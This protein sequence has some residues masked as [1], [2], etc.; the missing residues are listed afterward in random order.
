[1]D[2]CDTITWC[3]LVLIL[4]NLSAGFT[5]CIILLVK[6]WLINHYIQKN[7]T[8]RSLGYMGDRNAINI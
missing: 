2:G 5:L 1:M 3:L 6:N 4:T 8:D 7:N